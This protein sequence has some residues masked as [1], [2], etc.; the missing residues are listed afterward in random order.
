MRRHVTLKSV[1]KQIFFVYVR[2]AMGTNEAFPFQT[3]WWRTLKPRLFF[4]LKLRFETER[5]RSINSL[6]STHSLIPIV[7]IE[8]TVPVT[9]VVVPVTN[10]LN[11]IDQEF[12]HI[13]TSDFSFLYRSEEFPSDEGT[14]GWW[15]VSSSSL[16]KLKILGWVPL[17][18][19]SSRAGKW[20]MTRLLARKSNKTNE[21]KKMK[22]K[23][24]NDRYYAM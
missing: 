18:A 23:G 10:G 21:L 6:P 5:R 14:I 2:R 1:E 24:M 13:G 4:K 16:I 15:R 7:T 9:V 22:L 3:A 12:L 20:P 19:S 11:Q 8:V 17:V